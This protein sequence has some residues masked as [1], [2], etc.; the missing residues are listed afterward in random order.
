MD[1]L[2]DVPWGLAWAIG[3]LIAAI[4]S[5]VGLWQSKT[6]EKL[7]HKLEVQ[8]LRVL[9]G[10]DDHQPHGP[11]NGLLTFLELDQ[12]V[13]SDL[14][15]SGLRLLSLGSYF[16]SLRPQGVFSYERV[17]ISVADRYGLTAAL[18]LAIFLPST[19]RKDDD[20][21]GLLRSFPT[22]S[23][24]RALQS[25]MSTLDLVA[26]GQTVHQYAA[27]TRR[28][29]ADE[30]AVRAGRGGAG[31]A[32]KEAGAAHEQR[33]GAVADEAGAAAHEA[34]AAERAAGAAL[35]QAGPL[36]ILIRGGGGA[37][38]GASAAE[39]DGGGGSGGGSGA[40]EGGGGSAGGGAAPV[41]GAAAGDEGGG[42]SRP[43]PPLPSP[44][45]L[46]RAGVL[47]HLGISEADAADGAPPLGPDPRPLSHLLPD[48]FGGN[49]GLRLTHNAAG[50][51]VSGVAAQ[52][53]NRLAANAL[54]SMPGAEGLLPPE[55]A[56]AAGGGGGGGGGGA[57]F[58]VQL[59]PGGPRLST[60]EGVLAALEGA[61]Y[62]LEATLRSN[63]TSFGAGLSVAA[64][65]GGYQ[66]IPLA[67][68]LRTGLWAVS[69]VGRS[70]ARMCM[71]AISIS[72]GGGSGSGG[73]GGGR[74]SRKGRG[75]KAAAG[76]GG[77]GGAGAALLPDFELEWCL[78]V[79]GFT[80]WLPY[81]SVAREWASGRP[82]QIEHE[83]GD[84]SAP[85]AT[86]ALARVLTA[87]T[88]VLNVAGQ[89]D[90]L[91]FGGYGYLGVCIDSAAAV[92]QALTGRCS[93]FPLVLG[94]E[95]KMGLM[96]AYHTAAGGVA[97][98]A[99]AAGGGAAG[100]ARVTRGRRRQQQAQEQAEGGAWEYAAEAAALQRAVAA[101]PCDALPEPRGA[102]DAAR[103]ALTRVAVPRTLTRLQRVVSER[104]AAAAEHAAAAAATLDKVSHP[105]VLA[106]IFE[107]LPPIEQCI[108]V[109]RLSRAWRRW[110][111]PKAEA[112]RRKRRARGGGA[113]HHLPLW[114]MQEA[115]SSLPQPVARMGVLMHAARH[116]DVSALAWARRA[117]APAACW[118]PLVCSAAA[119]GGSLAAL[120]W[121]R[122]Q[123]PPCPWDDRACR[124]SGV[125]GH[126]HVLQWLRQQE[127]PCPWDAD[128]CRVAAVRRDVRVLQWLRQQEPPCPWDATTHIAAAAH[129]RLHV[130]Q[131]LRQQEPPCPWDE[132]TCRSAVGHG[133][134][135]VLQLLRQQEPPCPWDEG[136]CASAA[137]YGH[138]DVLQWLREQEPPCPWDRDACL[139]SAA[140]AK[141]DEV[142]AW[143]RAQE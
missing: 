80:G 52:A 6:R 53:F 23:A 41:L 122:R 114:C 4:C 103:R 120:R 12:Q 129:G 112:L 82:F 34:D 96:A 84:L 77:R 36:H 131:W 141:Y 49:G 28:H 93:L 107:R 45:L 61:G 60:L 25:A 133:H 24:A 14:S 40:A 13:A 46:T 124:A 66:Q 97:A 99:P 68:P 85:G 37:P 44:L 130:L 94:G 50:H 128:V 119:S 117:C 19:W 18:P 3:G 135:H 92:Q 54:R 139:E 75:G 30:A 108:S 118:G 70:C 72:S 98:G 59:S 21:G 76:G 73:G 111:A 57:P 9:D 33:A 79:N 138:L 42:A 87:A 2:E 134:L 10:P 126:V 63:I 62:D 89:R 15:L 22:L 1:A 106:L 136:A 116:G 86:A 105:V 127:P 142:V 8:V 102:A 55:F 81:S 78:G 140:M 7:Q 47:G 143:I 39:V 109:A 51:A 71:G 35:Q 43:A 32:P 48:L 38:E 5:L 113:A 91:L 58:E 74:S 115:W 56:A 125:H 11:A 123:Q 100:G 65:G 137:A 121:L 110:A 29:A 104:A 67:Y 64:E 88:C 95:A 101:L 16:A 90:R 31:A 17:V 69:A 26:F 83:I 132:E 20:V 27:R